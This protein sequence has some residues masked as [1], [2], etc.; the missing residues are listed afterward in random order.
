[1]A[2][3][4]RAQVVVDIPRRRGPDP[5]GRTRSARSAVT[6]IGALTPFS[7]APRRGGN[8]GGPRGDSA[9]GPVRHLP[10]KVWPCRLGLGPGA[11]VLARA[12]TCSGSAGGRLPGRQQDHQDAQSQG[13]ATDRRLPAHG[14][15][16]EGQRPR[17]HCARGRGR[18]TAPDA[19]A[20]AAR[21]TTATA[22]DAGAARPAA[23]AAPDGAAR[24]TAATA[25]DAAA[26]ADAGAPRPAA[27]APSPPSAP[28]G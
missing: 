19:A 23:A 6:L 12:V 13:G 2:R 4:A 25:T 14:G 5:R 10:P 11:L 28:E 24:P 7:A 16:G 20:A 1:M 17:R 8:A 26:A 15:A 9:G 3:Q 21:P 27:A 18:P 22:T